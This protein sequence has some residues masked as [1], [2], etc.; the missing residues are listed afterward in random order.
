MIK[1]PDLQFESKFI[2]ANNGSRKYDL[3]NTIQGHNSNELKEDFIWV[4]PLAC[5]G[6]IV[7]ILV[8]TVTIYVYR[9]YYNRPE[10]DDKGKKNC[11][12]HI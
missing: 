12:L 5:G 2:I 8:I 10:S 1:H 6:L 9:K 3:G 11:L 7:F 4:I